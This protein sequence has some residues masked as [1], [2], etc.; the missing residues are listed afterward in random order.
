LRTIEATR[1]TLEPQ[2][3][4]HAE[5]TFSV[6]SDPAIYVYENSPPRSLQWL[7]TRFEKLE[8]RRSP[9]GSQLWLNWVVRLRSGALI[10]YVQA[11]VHQNG[12]AAIAYE[13]SSAYWGRG[14][15]YEAADALIR[16]LVERYDVFYLTAV[17]KRANLRSLR[18]LERLGFSVAA[19]DVLAA[20]ELEPGETLFVRQ[21]G[22]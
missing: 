2:L 15:A 5:E 7:R 20:Y 22:L 10:G 4:S 17:A 18:L 6:L 9:D 21:M 19:Q 13:F 12:Q 11:T 14:L 3:A 16:E 8:S 1:L